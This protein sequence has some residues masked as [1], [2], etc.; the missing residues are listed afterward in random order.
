M[1]NETGKLHV[2]SFGG[3]FPD[4]ISEPKYEETIEE[5]LARYNKESLE[6]CPPLPEDWPTFTT[7]EEIGPIKGWFWKVEGVNLEAQ[8]LILKPHRETKVSKR[9]NPEK[10]KRKKSRRR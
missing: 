8:T 5:R 1:N 2:A 3:V 9:L 10:R 4:S 6:K 7:G